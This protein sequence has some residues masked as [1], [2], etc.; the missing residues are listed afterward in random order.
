ME[1]REQT[2]QSV[3]I[4]SSRLDLERA[5]AASNRS[6]VAQKVLF[7]VVRRD[8]LAASRTALSEAPTVQFVQLVVLQSHFL[9]TTDIQIYSQDYSGL[10]KRVAV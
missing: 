7:Q 4:E 6:V 3:Q 1:W 8:R 2:D 10:V 5:E 9:L